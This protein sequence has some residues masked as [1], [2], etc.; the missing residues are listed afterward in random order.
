MMRGWWHWISGG[1]GNMVWHGMV[2]VAV[3]LPLAS[4]TIDVPRYYS[5]RTRLQLA[6]D[7]SAEASARCLDFLHFQNIGESRLL[8]DCVTRDSSTIFGL[9]TQD[10][11]A[12][13]YQPTLGSVL[14]DESLDTVAVDASGRT[15]LFFG[16]TPAFAVEVRAVSSFRMDKR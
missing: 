7:G 3:L 9:A 5:L 10:L 11:A 2:L 15:T 12:K 8:P 14:V 6:A 16:M 1:D 13:G 4:L